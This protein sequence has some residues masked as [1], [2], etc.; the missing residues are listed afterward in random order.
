MKKQFDKNIQVLRGLCVISVVLFHLFPEEIPIGYL[1][2][3]VFFVISGFL[4][5]KLYGE[6]Q[7]RREIRRFYLNRF[8]RLL[9][10]YF[11][12][13]LAT[14]LVS[15]VLLLPHE[16]S[17]LTQHLRWSI[18]LLPNV[19]YWTDS[20]Y[21][22]S[23]DFR[24]ILNLWSLGVEL[25]FYLIF[26]LLIRYLKK[27]SVLI[28]LASANFLL[29]LVTQQ[30]SE[31]SA[32]FLLPS[33][34]WEFLVGILAF[35][36]SEQSAH[37]TFHYRHKFLLASQSSFLLLFFVAPLS[38]KVVILVIWAGY[39]LIVSKSIQIRSRRFNPLVRVGDYSYSIYLVHYPLL[40][41]IYYQP[42][43]SNSDFNSLNQPYK[44][45]FFLILLFFLSYCLRNYVELSKKISV[46]DYRPLIITIIVTLVLTLFPNF[47]IK[48]M[49]LSPKQYLI[50][51]SVLDYA[52]YRCGKISRLMSPLADVCRLN[53]LPEPSKKILLIGDSHADMLKKSLLKYANRSNFEL[54]LWRKNESV[55][56]D[57]FNKVKKV[58]SSG[59]FDRV[60]VTSNYGGTDF[61]ALTKIIENMKNSPIDWVYIDSI[62]TYSD[63]IPKVLFQSGLDG[64][65]ALELDKEDYLSSRKE[66][67]KFIE[68]NEKNPRFQN[69]SLTDSLCPKRCLIQRGGIPIYADSNH[70]TQR[71][72][73]RLEHLLKPA[74]AD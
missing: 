45:A 46:S 68:V 28:T 58:A 44:L 63:S 16:L 26:P 70:L 10:S 37:S 34:L 29:Y 7:T 62:P 38:A 49:Q 41:F 6:I 20:Q 36:L 9:P 66:E 72:V 53:E 48:R 52:P 61:G 32:F 11:I 50:S 19:G 3:D 60:I 17:V 74:I 33:R 2:V 56:I 73:S 24:P 1:G 39:F 71:E 57:N 51:I 31:K 8:R 23:A 25:Q 21:W 13:I 22:G 27:N 4:M 67:L 54:W 65:R 40:S 47:N 42:F 59:E 64:I 30:I 5:A 35:R 12:T 18:L 55:R 43:K 15:L 14:Y 69:V